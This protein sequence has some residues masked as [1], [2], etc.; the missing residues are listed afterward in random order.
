MFGK[1]VGTIFILLSA[2]STVITYYR[3]C[4]FRQ[5]YMAELIW[6]LEHIATEIRWK[7][8]T[9]PDIFEELSNRPCCGKT[10]QKLMLNMKS[11][12]P[13]QISWQKAFSENECE[14]ETIMTHADLSGD[15]KHLTEGLLYLAGE[16]KRALRTEK[17]KQKEKGKMVIALTGGG[18][19][20]LIILLM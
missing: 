6:S 17:E 9:L 15:E 18:A 1:T 2:L 3:Q 8:R 20:L 4:R 7:H 19:G 10:F 13:L 16:L 14:I 11:G 5:E 12:M